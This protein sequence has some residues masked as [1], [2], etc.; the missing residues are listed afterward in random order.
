MAIYKIKA[1]DGRLIS[2]QG[3]D[4]ASQEEVI[5]RAQKLYQPSSQPPA[6]AL[7]PSV[8]QIAPE[9][10]IPTAP[11]AA[12][13]DPSTVISGAPSPVLSQRLA[14]PDPGM[15]PFEADPSV[16]AG[17]SNN[18][19]DVGRKIMD[20]TGAAYQGFGNVIDNSISSAKL[21]LARLF[22][23]DEELNRRSANAPA[24][25]MAPDDNLVSRSARAVADDAFGA[26]NKLES[27]QMQNPVDRRGRTT[28]DQIIADPLNV[29]QIAKFGFETGVESLPEMATAAIPVIGPA[30]FG[31]SMNEGIAQQRAQND[32]R[33]KS[34]T[35]FKDRL[36]AAPFAAISAITERLGIKGLG[37]T[38]KNA[39]TR[40]AKSAAK[41]A[42]TEA[43]QEPIELAG[44][45]IATDNE[46]SAKDYGK[47]SLGGAI[48]GVTTGGGLKGG[49]EVAGAI[50]DAT[51]TKSASYSPFDLGAGT[52]QPVNE[53]PQVSQPSPQSQP[54]VKR[55]PAQPPSAPS[56][57]APIAPVAP[58]PSDPPAKAPPE[59]AKSPTRKKVVTPDG[60]I[61]IDTE[62][63]IV[64]LDSLQSAS[65]EIQPRDRSR[66]TSDIQ[67]QDIASK[68]DPE[69]LGDSRTT[70]MGSP[71]VG[72]DNQV[73]SGNGRTAAIR[74]A[75][76]A[77]GEQAE[78]YRQSL[79]ARGYKIDG[80]KN[81]VLIRRRKTEMTPEERVRFTTLSN[82]PQ[83]AEMSSTEKAKADALQIDDNLINL[84]KG[85]EPNSMDNQDFIRAFIA[86]IVTGNESSSLIGPD[87]NINQEG[88]KRAKAAMVA[89]AYNDSDL[90]ENIFENA[91]PEIRSIGN[92][93][94]DRAPEF[95]Q[96]GAA[97]RAKETPARFDITKQ[98]MDAVRIIRD[99]KRDGKSIRDVIEGTKQASLIDE[100]PI[101]PM[102]EKIVRSMYRPGLGRMLSQSA[103]DKVLRQYAVTAREQKE[104]DLFGENTK[105]PAD[106]LDAAYEKISGELEEKASGQGAL[107]DAG[108]DGPMEKAAPS[109]GIARDTDAGKP[110]NE[111]AGGLEQD[112]ITA[113]KIGTPEELAKTSG[114]TF[115]DVSNNRD[116]NINKQVFK[117]AGHDPE[118][119]VNYAPL[120]QR[121]III[122]Q[123]MS[124]FGMK[125]ALDEKMKIKDQI[126]HLADMYVGMN[127]MAAVLGIPAKGM[128]LNGRLTVILEGGNKPYLGQY[129]HD[130]AS[131]AQIS[132]PKKSNSF[133][134]E[135]LHALDDWMMSRFGAMTGKPILFSQ[136]VRSDGIVDLSN[137][138]QSSFANLLNALFYDKAFLASKILELQNQIDKTKSE[139]VKNDAQRK[140][141]QIKS[142]N[143]A[144]IAGKT[145]FYKNA[146]TMPNADYFASP[147]EMMAR[148]FEAFIAYKLSDAGVT[149]RAVSKLDDAYNSNADERLAKTFPK[150]ADRIHIFEAFDAFFS[151][152]SMA[153]VMG[154][155]ATPQVQADPDYLGIFDPKYWASPETSEQQAAANMGFVRREIEFTKA[156]IKR[157]KEERAIKNAEEQRNQKIRDT[158]DPKEPGFKGF[159]KRLGKGLSDSSGFAMWNH[160][161]RTERTLAHAIEK[162]Y[163]GITALRVLN[164]RVFTRPGE[165]TA[166]NQTYNKNI[167]TSI[168]RDS[169]ILENLMSTLKSGVDKKKTKLTADENDQLRNAILGL[170]IDAS[171]LTGMTEKQLV[172]AAA[173]LRQ[174]ADQQWGNMS[175]AGFE[176]GYYEKGAWLRRHYMRDAIMADLSGF[177]DKAELTYLDQFDEVFPN[178]DAAVKNI[179]DFVDMVKGMLRA[180]P[181][182][183]SFDKKSLQAIIDAAN[184]K[185]AA[186]LKELIDDI[187][188]E[189]REQYA[190]LAAKA[191]LKNLVRDS[192]G[193]EF[194]ST[195]PRPGFMKARGLPVSAD[196]HMKD[197]METN[198]E[199]ILF[200]YMVSSNTAIAQKNV[201]NPAGEQSMEQLLNEARDAGANADDIRNLEDAINRVVHGIQLGP[202]GRKIGQ[203]ISLMRMGGILMNLNKV[204]FAA[205]VEPMVVGL[206]T[207]N[208]TNAAMAYRYAI[209]DMLNTGEAKY[210]KDIAHLI[211]AIGTDYADMMQQERFGGGFE[212]GLLNRETMSKFF[213]YTGNTGITNI[214]SRVA[215]R[216]GY[217]WMSFVAEKLINGTAKE[218]SMAE[219]DLAELGIPGGVYAKAFSTWLLD[220]GGKPDINSVINDSSNVFG[221]AFIVAANR[222]RDEAVQQPKKE[223]RPALANHPVGAV[224]YTGLGF[225]FSFWDNVVKAEAK[226]AK[227]ILQN[228]GG[229]AFAKVVAN[230]VA[231]IGSMVV[232][233]MLIGALKGAIFDSE[234][235]KKEHAK[236][237][238][239]YTMMLLG[240][241]LENTNLAGPAYSI[242]WNMYRGAEYGK[243]PA[244][245]LSGMV[246]SNYLNW[247]QKGLELGGDRNSPNNT[248]SE[249]EFVKQTFRVMAAPAITAAMLNA[250]GPA[251][252]LAVPTGVA[253][254]F[255]NSSA[256]SDLVAN[257]IIGEKETGRGKKRSAEPAEPK[258]PKEPKTE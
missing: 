1:P 26:A 25:L 186:K 147:H 103:I 209:E 227:A 118:A 249:R 131:I 108:Q 98:L 197:Y 127:N 182:G 154:T 129:A 132:L 192:S 238:E 189:V 126:D 140:I 160:F 70:D 233:S 106:L 135:F 196:V 213:R 68:L 128:S 184:D 63:E 8:P 214:E 102:V 138:V 179:E 73:E 226:R 20:S 37:S 47:A 137:P 62:D 48:G 120:K 38:G 231:T 236:D 247:L 89:K 225:T 93:L 244:T 91:D 83:I 79:I 124:K 180:D 84:H 56:V 41:E 136:A 21:N 195:F 200:H 60:S 64:D 96:L 66:A 87:K 143:Y 171:K 104:N 153:Q 75:Y 130:G 54:A 163:Q 198:V 105:Q 241:G 61:E 53:I 112:A 42:G 95:A 187:F 141:D 165:A 239:K 248:N 82:K 202:T 13:V 80:I 232:I 212:M 152:V 44:Q 206:K 46:A 224:L 18:A 51:E 185:D 76:Q 235:K 12:T 23:G 159:V 203:F 88:I 69:R 168:N 148:A 257:T 72:P 167:S 253:A 169:N 170:K 156:A 144:G 254:M 133:A 99:A 107:L 219:R 181:D 174:F 215:I 193:G 256:T 251:R 45:S 71:I 243:D 234:E 115:G 52:R 201:M 208:V 205:V 178:S 155:D 10:V 31:L 6:P 255:L 221:H 2:L 33:D 125:V 216:S 172:S 5:A 35:T 94:R 32:G 139:K 191:W 146:R 100:A 55:E 252:L 117:D 183:V 28:I 7:P 101:D 230:H 223:D 204:V 15:G 50:K 218:K 166:V 222:F 177:T 19:L 142:G 27:I 250:P 81:P 11:I 77:N 9:A 175:K 14:E 36:A 57:A 43:I 34:E 30:A 123:I 74:M 157:W 16:G 24:E 59:G 161:Y 67:I 149:T 114:R 246:L 210:F 188:D 173:K 49:A 245:S 3:P 228:E 58:M 199:R 220:Q 237:P 39:V 162:K 92:A 86:K 164:D 217:R 211:G 190:G 229:A 145:D 134:H 158:L 109:R 119:A 151:A 150:L 40:T 29:P 116:I 113:D 258:E 176:I 110:A 207:R 240:R 4:G 111:S 90:V 122:D 22:I 194:E 97:V 85:G 121:K 65:G 17:F 78:K 242:M